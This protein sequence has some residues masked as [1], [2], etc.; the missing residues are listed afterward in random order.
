MKR[1]GFGRKCLS[2][3]CSSKE[4]RARRHWPWSYP[5]IVSFVLRIGVF[6]LL[7]L[8]NEEKNKK[9]LW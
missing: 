1:A 6:T 3:Q 9:M 2:Y 4:L 7:S 5:D 8:F